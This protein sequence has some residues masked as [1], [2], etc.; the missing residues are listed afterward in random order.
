MFQIKTYFCGITI[1]EVIT[2][3]KLSNGHRKPPQVWRND[4]MKKMDMLKD[5]VRA[6]KNYPDYVAFVIDDTSYTY[7]RYLPE[8]GE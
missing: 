2:Y 1:V 6:Y 3:H 5:I 8:Y 7:K 4:F